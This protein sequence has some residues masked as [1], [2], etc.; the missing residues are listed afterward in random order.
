M[1]CQLAAAPC[2]HVARYADLHGNLLLSKLFDQLGI[3]DR[4]QPM[5]NPL[6]TDVQRRPDRFRTDTLAGMR[7]KV[8]TVLLGESV[9]C[10]KLLRRAFQLVT[11]YA[12]ADN[13]G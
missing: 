4:M 9:G 3:L 6:R 5:P 2:S 8:Q 12:N 11:T 7:G 13:A 10:T 1:L